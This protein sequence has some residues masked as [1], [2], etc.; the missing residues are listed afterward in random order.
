[1][2]YSLLSMSCWYSE[3]FPKFA[4]NHKEGAPLSVL[5]RCIDIVLLFTTKPTHHCN[6]ICS[7][8]GMCSVC[9]VN[10]PLGLWRVE[11]CCHWEHKLNSQA[12][13]KAGML[14]QS[15]GNHIIF[16]IKSTEIPISVICQFSAKKKKKSWSRNCRVS[17]PH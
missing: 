7:C 17:H 8:D 3:L 14:R 11:K 10:F 12:H 2:L 15:P 13:F 16:H 4:Q 1:M 5:L 9:G 6:G